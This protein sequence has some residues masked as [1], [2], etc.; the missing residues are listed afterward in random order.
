MLTLK[1]VVTDQGDFAIFTELTSHDKIGENLFGKPVAAGFCHLEHPNVHE[2]YKDGESY[3]ICSG[4]SISLGLK[5]RGEVDEKI[6]N[7]HL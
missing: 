1:Y 6:I 5:S 3:I 2:G 4:D 7:K